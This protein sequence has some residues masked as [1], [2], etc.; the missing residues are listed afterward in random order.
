MQYSPS[1]PRTHSVRFTRR[2]V[3]AG[4]CRSKTRARKVPDQGVD[5]RAMDASVL[6]RIK[7]WAPQDATV[8]S[9][10]QLV[11]GELDDLPEQAFLNVG[12]AD[13]A[14]AKAAQLQKDT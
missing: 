2:R 6:G 11:N 7:K 5:D 12:N 1:T 9:F 8:E 3:S 10:E 14:R 4:G 13:S